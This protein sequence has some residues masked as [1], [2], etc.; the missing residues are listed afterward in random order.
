MGSRDDAAA[1]QAAVSSTIGQCPLPCAQLQLTTWSTAALAQFRRRHQSQTSYRGTPS[2]RYR[3]SP[4]PL[5]LLV[6][7]VSLRRTTAHL[8][9]EEFI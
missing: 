2:R 1:G 6:S 8:T 7:G 3:I 5:R 9:S 4:V